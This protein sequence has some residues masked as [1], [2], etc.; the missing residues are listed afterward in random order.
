MILVLRWPLHSDDLL[1]NVNGLKKLK[2]SFQWLSELVQTMPMAFKNA[3]LSLPFGLPSTLI[4]H[5]SGS[6]FKT[7]FK[8]EE[9]KLKHRLR[10]LTRVDGE[11]FENVTVTKTK[12]FPWTRFSSITN[13]NWPLIV[14]LFITCRAKLLN[15]DWLRQRAF[16]LNQE[17]TF[18]NQEGMITWCWLAE[19]AC[20]KLVSRFKRI[21]KRNFR[22]AS[23]LSLILTW[24]FHPNGK[25]HQHA[26]KRCLLVE[27]Q[28]DFSDQ[29]HIDS[30]RE[31]S[32]SGDGWCW[33][34]H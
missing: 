27:K 7:L 5:E 21:L 4:R 13:P 19:H 26:T 14:A 34:K 6:F 9:F 10:V 2:V 20:I 31:N 25:E 32:L 15:A 22:N 3:A 29:K 8:P 17:G 23:L 18:G 1:T 11:V 28:I 16:F 33:T 30:Q 24:S 12:W